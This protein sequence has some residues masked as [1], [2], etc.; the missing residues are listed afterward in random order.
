M[1]QKAAL[2]LSGGGARGIA[3]IGVIEELVKK[4]FD[5]TSIAGTS[6]GAV[7]GGVYALGKLEEYK[8]WLYTLDKIKLFSLV[9]FT[10][11]SQGLV[12]GDKLLNSVKTF[13]P[14]ANIEDLDIPYAAVAADIIH[15]KE[16]VFTT[17][18]L[19]EAIRASMAIPTVFTPVKF[20]DGLLID[21]G[22]I[23]NMPINRIKR[24]PGD[25]LIAVNV[26]ADIPVEK[27]PIA[28]TE[29]VAIQ[30]TYQ[31]KL[32]DFYNQLHILHPSGNEEKSN[33]E[34]KLGYFNL[35]NKTLSFMTYH[36]TQM[37]LD[38]YTP[39]ILVDVSRH[40]CGTFD[41]YR[42]EEMVEVGRYAAIKCLAAY[43]PA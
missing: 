34:E 27:P 35:I 43:N 33:G 23:N 19:F 32:K 20:E 25:I 31:K 22:I 18:S 13:I 37:T 36:I 12:K 30:S 17:G 29:T 26:N 10:L 21:G 39:D 7:V 16:V 5:I 38:N 15:K 11:S 8:N 9:D 6:M 40:A 3:H 2:V 14:D 1:K 28:K 41:F 4:G 42:A 24:T